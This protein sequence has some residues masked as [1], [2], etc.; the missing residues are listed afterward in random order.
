LAHSRFPFMAG[1]DPAIQKTEAF[2]FMT[3]WPGRSPA[4]T[5]NSPSPG[6]AKPYP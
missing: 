5:A 6:K 3:G 2:Q 1:L 4:M